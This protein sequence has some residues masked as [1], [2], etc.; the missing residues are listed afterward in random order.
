MTST[1][2]T[3]PGWYPD[4]TAPET[5]RY[6]DGHGWTTAT[7]GG[8]PQTHLASGQPPVATPVPPPPATERPGRTLAGWALG[9]SI[10]GWVL[11]LLAL[12]GL[13]L[14][15]GAVVKTAPHRHQ[16]GTTGHGM[17]IAAIV[18]ASLAVL[19]SIGANL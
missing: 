5:Q 15:I 2:T 18:L 8:T 12:I 19:G 13:G 17:A 10:A 4:P 9:V 7:S 16:P 11:P 3:A 1:S 14:G 6:W